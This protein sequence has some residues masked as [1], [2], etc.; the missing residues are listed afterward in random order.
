MRCP[1]KKTTPSLYRNGSGYYDSTAGT[2][3]SNII[4]NA[5][6]ELRKSELRNKDSKKNE[7]IKRKQS[8]KY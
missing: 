5:K 1:W 6:S 8:A 2:A 3:L 7:R 4:A